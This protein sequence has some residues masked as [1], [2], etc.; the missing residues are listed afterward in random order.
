MVIGCPPYWDTA[1]FMFDILRKFQSKYPHTEIRL[2]CKRFHELEK[3]VRSG[4]LDIIIT[5]E[6]MLNTAD[7]CVKA[8]TTVP[9]LLLYSVNHPQARLGSPRAADFRDSV[10]FLPTETK[11]AEKLHRSIIAQLGFDTKFQPLDFESVVAR[12]LNGLGVCLTDIWMR[13]ILYPG[14]R[15]VALDAGS[16]IIIAWRKANTNVNIELFSNE[17][18]FHFCGNS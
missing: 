13:D 9:F 15:T 10:F 8:L 6:C 12:V 4:L 11:Q 17:L 3:C 18:F 14:I 2:E 16:T 7:L 1:S 5:P